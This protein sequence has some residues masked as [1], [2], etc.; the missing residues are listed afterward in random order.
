MHMR[1]YLGVLDPFRHIRAKKMLLDVQFQAQIFKWTIIG[2]FLEHKIRHWL[3]GE[4]E[5][6]RIHII[7]A[8]VTHAEHNLSTCKSN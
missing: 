7:T 1:F 2:E 4:Q 5:I 8:P 6:D 3:R